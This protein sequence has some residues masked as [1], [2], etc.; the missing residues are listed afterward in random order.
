MSM[1]LDGFAHL[2]HEGWERVASGYEKWWS[3]L[4]RQ[5]VEPLLDGAEVKEGTR[6]LDLAC[7]PG[8]VSEAAAVR[9]AVPLGLDFSPNMVEIARNRLPALRFEVGD[10]Q[11]I[12]QDDESFD[13]VVMGFGL[14]H[15]AEPEHCLAEA[16]RV[17]R[18][19]G[20]FAYSVW[21]DPTGCPG[22]RIVSDAVEAHADLS[23][24][25]PK[26]PDVFR[27]GDPAFSREALASAGFSP[28]SYRRVTQTR[29]FRVPTPGFL[30][31]AERDGGVRTGAVLAVQTPER[32]AAIRAAVERGVAA[33][34]SGDGYELPM[35]AHVVSA[36]R[37]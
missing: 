37:V 31:E 24:P 20:W 36:K 14:L 2:E 33:Y 7:G 15:L 6:V 1:D 25:V 27:L 4:T 26:G 23:V 3:S 29:G 21:A 13:A 30:F 17:L 8:Y 11:R 12:V 35:T 5:F 22:M 10:A 19:G 34:P 28:E 18:E 9:G 16:R 32:L